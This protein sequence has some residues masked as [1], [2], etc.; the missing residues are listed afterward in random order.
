MRRSKTREGYGQ[1]LRAHDVGS[2]FEPGCNRVWIFDTTL[3]DGGQ[4]RGVDFSVADKISI[5]RCLDDFG[6]DY[7]EGGWPGANPT[8]TLFF[9]GAPK[10]LQLK[11]AKL[12]AF[13]MTRRAGC[14]AEDDAGLSEVLRAPTHATC[15]FGKT[16]DFQVGGLSACGCAAQVGRRVT[17]WRWPRWRWR[18]RSRSRRTWR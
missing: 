10:S 6:V 9:S 5:A 13:G 7:I 11:R 4:T 18:S 3:R 15:I 17:F 1:P 14:R 12:V 8:D 2:R 16:W